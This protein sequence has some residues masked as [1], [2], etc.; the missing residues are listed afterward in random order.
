MKHIKI[1]YYNKEGF[2]L[3]FS[4]NDPLGCSHLVFIFGILIFR[5]LDISWTVYWNIVRTLLAQDNTKHITR[6]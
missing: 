4:R 6:T 2:I 1:N 3:R 5:D